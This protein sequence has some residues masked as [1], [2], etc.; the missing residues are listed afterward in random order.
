[1]EVSMAAELKPRL[2]FEEYLDL[3]SKADY[4]SEFINGQMYMMAGASPNHNLLTASMITELSLQLKKRPCRV[5]SSDQLLKIERNENGRYPDVTVVCGQPQYEKHPYLSALLNPTL[6]VEILSPSNAAYDRD[7]KAD[8]YRTI[9]SLQE[10][11]LVAQNRIHVEHYVRQS[12][13]QWLLT[14]Y[15]ALDDVIHLASIQ[16]DLVLA[17]VYGKVEWGESTGQA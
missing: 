14:E 13:N 3:E 6:L 12:K 8:E 4:K 11:L 7:V 15:N 9:A 10:Y 1:M 5:Y 17:D 2:T 16:C